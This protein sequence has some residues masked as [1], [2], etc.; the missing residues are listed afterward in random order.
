MC[1]KMEMYER[2]YIALIA[3]WYETCI[4]KKKIEI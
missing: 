4:A 3:I 1:L 2:M